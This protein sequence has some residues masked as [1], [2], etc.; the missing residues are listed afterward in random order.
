VRLSEQLR[1]DATGRVMSIRGSK[2]MRSGPIPGR[3]IA[4]TR[5]APRQS[6]QVLLFSYGGS[7]T[8]NATLQ[9]DKPGALGQGKRTEVRLFAQFARENQI[10]KFRW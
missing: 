3:T 2:Q 7:C 6:G 9:G 5:R 10:P 4:L 1:L 8:P